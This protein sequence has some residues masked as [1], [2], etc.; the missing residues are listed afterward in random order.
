MLDQRK[1]PATARLLSPRASTPIAGI[2]SPLSFSQGVR[3]GAE[4][5]DSESDD[6][7]HDG[8]LSVASTEPGSDT[9]S[10]GSLT[11]VE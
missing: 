4:S 7:D 1:G 6:D 5:H 11:S 9:H 8:E 3:R 10:L 2:R